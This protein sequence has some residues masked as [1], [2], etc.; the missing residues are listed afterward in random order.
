MH[1]HNYRELKTEMRKVKNHERR[2]VLEEEL[3]DL[4]RVQQQEAASQANVSEKN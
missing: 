4:Q 2:A 1:T 3:R